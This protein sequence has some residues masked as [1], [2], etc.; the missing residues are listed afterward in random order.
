MPLDFSRS[1]SLVG[2]AGLCFTQPLRGPSPGPLGTPLSFRFSELPPFSL[3]RG[4]KRR[5]GFRR[6]GLDV[7]LPWARIWLLVAFTAKETENAV[8]LRD[9]GGRA[10]RTL[11]SRVSSAGGLACSAA[12]LP[13]P[14]SVAVP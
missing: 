14:C 11:A 13:R 8:S 4:E 7:E 10:T 6:P 5:G 9:P 2:G 1:C 3:L 12:C